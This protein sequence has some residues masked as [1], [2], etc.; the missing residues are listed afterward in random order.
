VSGALTAEDLLALQRA[1]GPRASEDPR[2]LALLADVA[3]KHPRAK[4]HWLPEDSEEVL[5]GWCAARLASGRLANLIDKAESVRALRSMLAKDLQQYANEVRRRNLPT[6]LYKRMHA[7]LTSSPDRYQPVLATKNPGSTSWTL[8]AR[9]AAAI[10]SGEDAEL[11]AHVFAVALKPLQEDPLAKKQSQF[12]TPTELERYVSE[13]LE[14]TARGV[15]LDQLTRGL[16]LTYNLEP[17]FTELPDESAL[18]DEPRE[19][20][21]PGIRRVEGP[22]L[23]DPEDAGAHALLDALT[24]RQI[25]VLGDLHLKVHQSETAKR[26]RCSAATISNELDAIGAVLMRWPEREEQLRVLR[27]TIDLLERSAR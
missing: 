6:K 19:S 26:L 13:M 15:S 25:Q 9:P 20:E 18:G 4:I 14:R 11:I 2:I 24:E 3:S 16:V 12:L 27:Q 22:A 17:T 8:A 7:I 5:G 21:P 23:P 1:G 10:F